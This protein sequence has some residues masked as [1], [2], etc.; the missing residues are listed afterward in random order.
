MEFDRDTVEFLS[1]LSPSTR[2]LYSVGLKAFQTF[3]KPQGMIKDFLDRV[4]EDGHSTRNE[5]RRIGRNTLKGFVEWLQERGY[6]SKTVRTYVAA[7][8]RRPN[9]STYPCPPAT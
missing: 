6:T 4:E 2:K 1:A 3:Y 7:S 5:R 8:S 9:T